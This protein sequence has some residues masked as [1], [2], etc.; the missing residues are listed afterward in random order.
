MTI[1]SRS[2]TLKRQR[3]AT[4]DPQTLGRTPQVDGPVP[5]GPIGPRRRTG[6]RGESVDLI[7]SRK[8]DLLADP[9]REHRP[10]TVVLGK[11]V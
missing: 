7:H 9:H 1:P 6:P 10:K 8:P 11:P 5:C 3:I 4:Q 2:V